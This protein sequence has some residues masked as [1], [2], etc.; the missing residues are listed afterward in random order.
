MTKKKKKYQSIYGS[1]SNPLLIA[2]KQK[3]KKNWKHKPA[4]VGT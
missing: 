1:L 4:N 2:Y 3:D